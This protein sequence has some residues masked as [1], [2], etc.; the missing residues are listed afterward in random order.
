MEASLEHA[1]I[2]AT[3]EP[4]WPF[5][6]VPGRAH[7]CPA[8]RK[9]VALR[10]APD[11]Q[12][13]FEHAPPDPA[14]APPAGYGPPGAAKAASASAA[15]SAA[16]TLVDMKHGAGVGAVGGTAARGAANA[17]N[18]AGPAR[19][20][21]G[22]SAGCPRFRGR[23]DVL[24]EA[25]ALLMNALLSAEGFGVELTR[26][27]PRCE[28][29]QVRTIRY[30]RALDPF[31]RQVAA[32][33]RGG[34]DYADAGA[35][36]LCF[37]EREPVLQI[38]FRPPQPRHFSQPRA[39]PYMHVDPHAAVVASIQRLADILSHLAFAAANPDGHA[40]EGAVNPPVPSSAAGGGAFPFPAP[41]RPTPSAPAVRALRLQVEPATGSSAS[42]C[43]RAE[44]LTRA[45]LATQLGWRRDR[46]S[47]RIDWGQDPP[48]V[49]QWIANACTGK[50]RRHVDWVCMPKPLAQGR[51][52][53]AL[54]AECRR[55]NGCL[56]C[57]ARF[58]PKEGGPDAHV[59][60]KAAEFW[61]YC[62]ACIPAR[63]A[64]G[65]AA[66]AP[67]RSDAGT[68]TEELMDVGERKRRQ[69]RLAWVF[70]LGYVR[71]PE[72]GHDDPA[73]PEPEK[74]CQDCGAES[75]RPLFYFGYR[76]I[77]KSCV[78]LRFRSHLPELVPPP[79]LSC[80][81]T[82]PDGE[83]GGGAAAKPS[84]PSAGE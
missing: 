84:G 31:C 47:D 69:G 30:D 54:R 22:G 74:P 18:S 21:S 28:I 71:R 66:A 35:D 59:S 78:W 25:R 1:L 57:G 49:T 6:A 34:E 73:T 5:L 77:C 26:S 41:T 64:P 24:A 58:K 2:A 67:G 10:T 20:G 27:C 50:I 43:G 14:P 15:H 13:F 46:S 68:L 42:T 79:L 17:V 75:Y 16:W 53:L 12:M 81:P 72:R 76:S 44:C 39:V 45:D 37:F 29:R 82:Q 56:R 33:A 61:P 38:G 8:C 36:L 83:R 4:V 51:A 63:R 48:D 9:P 11:R 65:G 70:K 7:M 80:A 19:G 32:M 40:P 52:L 55:R 62:D 3:C 23:P 60:L